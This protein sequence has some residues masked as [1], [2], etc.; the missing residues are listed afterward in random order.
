MPW[1]CLPLRVDD[2]GIDLQG[3]MACHLVLLAVL[4]T[5]CFS[6]LTSAARPI[7]LKGVLN[8]LTDQFPDPLRGQ[9]GDLLGQDA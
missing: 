8:G 7:L 3:E 6:S 2:T 9:R 5:P 4:P 1:P